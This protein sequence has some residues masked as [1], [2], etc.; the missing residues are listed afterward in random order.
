MYCGVFCLGVVGPKTAIE[1]GQNIFL[2]RPALAKSKTCECERIFNFH[3]NS[4]S[5]S[6]VADKSAANKYT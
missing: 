3:P 2:I 6:A 4:I 5:F 1:D